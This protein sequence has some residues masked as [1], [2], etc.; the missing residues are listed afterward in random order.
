MKTFAV[1]SNAHCEFIDITQKVREVLKESGTFE[2][3]VTVY[4][5]HTTAGVTINENGDP[6]V[7]RDLLFGLNRMVPNDGFHHFEHNSDAHLKTLLTGSS[8]QVFAHGN[9]LQLGTWQSI[10]FCEFDGPRNR[11]V[12]VQII[13]K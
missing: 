5:P 4:I 2:G 3:I 6:D 1:Q 8:V 7:R 9:E 13:N 10:Y 12:M 11:K